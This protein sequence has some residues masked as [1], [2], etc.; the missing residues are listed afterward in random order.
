MIELGRGMIFPDS[1]ADGPPDPPDPHWN[2][3]RCGAH[4]GEDDA[5]D[6]CPECGAEFDPVVDD[7]G[8]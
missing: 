3:W 8:E 2:C 7:A 6:D 5:D 1:W 4:M